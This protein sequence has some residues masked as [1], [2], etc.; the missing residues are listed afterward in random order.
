MR[1]PTNSSAL[2]TLTCV[3]S[4]TDHL[5]PDLD[6]ILGNLIRTIP[7][8]PLKDRSAIYTS[9]NLKEPIKKDLEKIYKV[10]STKTWFE[11][12]C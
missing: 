7:R 3:P 6:Q 5:I 12:L 10:D 11:L 9:I 8:D 1:D 4:H 2:E